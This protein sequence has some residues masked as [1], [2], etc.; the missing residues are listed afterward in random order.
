MEKIFITTTFKLCDN[1]GYL[2]TQLSNFFIQNGFEP[3]ERPEHADAIVISTCGFDQERENLSISVVDGYICKFANEKKI[4]ICG[5]LPQINPDLFDRSKVTLIGPKELYRFNDI[6]NPAIKIE[7]ISGSRLNEKFITRE[8][9]FIGTYYLQICQGCQNNCSYCAIKKA[10]GRVKSKPVEKVIRDLEEGIKLGF[11]R[12]MLLADDCGSYGIDLGLNLSDLLNPLKEYDIGILINYIEPSAFQRLYPQIDAKILEKIEFMNIPV[13]ATSGRII[14]LMSRDY[15]VD[16]IMTIAKDIKDRFPHIYLETHVI[17]GFP[18][19]TGEDFR[20]TF[21]LSECF[22]GV[23]YFYYTDRIGTRSSLL[24]DKVSSSE[25]IFRTKEIMA[26]PRFAFEHGAAEPPLI[27]L[28]YGLD[29]S[30][31]FES[32]KRNCPEQT[33]SVK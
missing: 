23:I 14:N 10:K 22:D 16:E 18:G 32:I 17:Y 1:N 12:V 5:C 7:D 3:V 9:G 33:D 19:E 29:P 24:P 2:G 30:D 28:G 4:I 26:H 6:F 8:Y 13:Q 15:D 11:R 27:L 31:L 21:R 20:D 25:V